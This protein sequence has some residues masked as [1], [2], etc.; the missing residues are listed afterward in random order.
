MAHTR[1]ISKG[2]LALGIK[3]GDRVGLVCESRYEWHVVDF[4]IQQIGA[5]VVAIYPNITDA[6]YQFIFNDAEI[7][8]C[9]VSN[10]NLMSASIVCLKAFG[11]RRRSFLKNYRP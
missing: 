1:E 9:I 8:L 2:L 6:E 3:P 4:A 11:R 10:K 7:Q 5:V